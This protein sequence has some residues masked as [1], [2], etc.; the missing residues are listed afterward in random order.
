MTGT[1]ALSLA[2]TAIDLP[3]VGAEDQVASRADIE[4]GH[5][6]ARTAARNRHL[7]LI[8]APA[9]D[10]ATLCPNNQHAAGTD[11]EFG[12]R[13]LG[14]AACDRYD[15]LEFGAAAIDLPFFGTDDQHAA[16]A[17]VNFLNIVVWR[18]GRP[19]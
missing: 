10:I 8:A 19:G 15:W 11:V 14:R 7:R 1:S 9:N 5:G 3:A 17:D 4:R 18:L 2:L 6:S 16:R 13:L 12:V